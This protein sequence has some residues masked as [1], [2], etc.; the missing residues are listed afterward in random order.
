[1]YSHSNFQSPKLTLWLVL[2]PSAEVLGERFDWADSGEES[3][4]V[5]SPSACWLSSGGP[6][7]FTPSPCL[8][9]PCPGRTASK[10]FLDFG[11]CLSVVHGEPQQNNGGKE[12]MRLGL[13][14]CR[15][16]WGGLCTYTE[17]T[18]SLKETLSA[19]CLGSTNH[20]LFLPLQDQRF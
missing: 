3:T 1:M 14:P 20:S 2:S 4:R 13:P 9:A 10:F 5:W 11:F 16:S 7:R 15:V 18:A 12:R 6:C 17:A 8:P 19:G